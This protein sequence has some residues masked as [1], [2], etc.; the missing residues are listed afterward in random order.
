MFHRLA[1]SA[2]ALIVVLAVLFLV[3]IRSNSADFDGD[4]LIE[5]L[6]CDELYEAYAFG[7]VVLKD[8]VEMYNNCRAYANSPADKGHG[9][10]HCAIIR[11]DG[12]F[13]QGLIND[14]ANVFNAKEEC[15][16]YKR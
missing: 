4:W 5:D 3:T 11:K 7:R 15:R 10:L 8:T 12:E 6:T 9:E 14:I 1:A 16:T 2:F 13:M